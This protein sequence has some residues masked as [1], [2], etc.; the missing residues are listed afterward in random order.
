MDIC[1]KDRIKCK[2]LVLKNFIINTIEN[3]Q[4]ILS[5]EIECIITSKYDFSLVQA[6]SICVLL[7]DAFHFYKFNI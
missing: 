3:Y 7:F 5:F 1:C 2:H 4:T 6:T